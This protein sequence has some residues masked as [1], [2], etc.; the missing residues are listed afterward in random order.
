EPPPPPSNVTGVE[1]S[2]AKTNTISWSYSPADRE[3][4]TGFRIYRAN[5]PPGHAFTAVATLYDTTAS[6]WVD[7]VDP[8]CGRAYYVVAL[9]TDYVTGG[10]LETAAST[11]SWYSRPCQ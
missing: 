7:S 2:T 9:Y 10:E 8:T 3:L 5:F 4:I 11:T 6:E 1:D